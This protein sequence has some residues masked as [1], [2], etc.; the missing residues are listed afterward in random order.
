MPGYVQSKT[1]C[2]FCALTLENTEEQKLILIQ[3]RTF[4]REVEVYKFCCV[5]CLRL[6]VQEHLKTNAAFQNVRYD[7]WSTSEPIRFFRNSR[8]VAVLFPSGMG[9]YFMT[10]D[11]EHLIDY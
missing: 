1:T 8:V 10:R 11:K 7:R 6:F 9:S 5:K 4:F 2:T 3:K